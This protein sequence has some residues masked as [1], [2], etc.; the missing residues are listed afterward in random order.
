MYTYNVCLSITISIY[1]SHVANHELVE[2]SASSL[3]SI[4]VG[5]IFMYSYIYTC[6]Y[7]HIH[8]Y[9]CTHICIYVFKT[10]N[11][12][13]ELVEPGTSSLRSIEVRSIFIYSIF[14]YSVSIYLYFYFFLSLWDSRRES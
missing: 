1:E 8:I 4:A 3:W 10:H 14:I 6:L 7:I 2:A 9:I 11:A 12:N 5:D 13:H